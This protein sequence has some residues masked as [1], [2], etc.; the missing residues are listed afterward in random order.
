MFFSQNSIVSR[1]SETLVSIIRVLLYEHYGA[2]CS[3]QQVLFLCIRMSS[4]PIDSLNGYYC[5][6]LI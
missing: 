6:T 5:E 2:M 3:Q 4:M 1:L